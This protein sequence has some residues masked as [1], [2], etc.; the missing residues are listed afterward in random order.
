MMKGWFEKFAAGPPPVD[1]VD[2]Y[3]SYRRGSSDVAVLTG[4]SLRIE[5]GECVFLTGPSGSGKSTLLSILGCILT[6]DLGEVRLFGIELSSLDERARVQLRRTRI[7][8]VFQRFQLI[9]GLSALENVTVPMVLR[10][11]S[12]RAMRHR[13][14]ELLEAVGLQM[15]MQAQPNQLSA[16]QCQRVAMA[17]AL[18]LNPELILADEPT[19]ALDSQNGHEVM[20]LL[21]DLTTKLGKTAVVVTHDQRIFAYADRLCRLDEGKLTETTDRQTGAILAPRLDISLPG[22]DLSSLGRAQI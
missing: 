7:G 16:G 5:R 9:R 4:A 15:H 2:V 19:A 10:G 20:Q 1:I 21:R 12:P 17:R 18:A 11:D 8:F 6:P 14:M 13:G 3:K 22:T